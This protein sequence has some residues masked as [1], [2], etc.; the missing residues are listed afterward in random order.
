MGFACPCGLAPTSGTSLTK[1]TSVSTFSVIVSSQ[2]STCWS[3][4]ST[5]KQAIA[6]KRFHRAGI[7]RFPVYGFARGG[8]TLAVEGALGGGRG[9]KAAKQDGGRSGIMLLHFLVNAAVQKFAQGD[10]A[11]EQAQGERGGCGRLAASH[12]GG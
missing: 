11:L 2:S 5:K 7:L 10:A 6:G 12:H 4:T 1:Q 3:P 9:D 8:N